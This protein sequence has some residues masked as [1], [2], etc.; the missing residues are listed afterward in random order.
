MA[1][2]SS[3]S[4]S[5]STSSIVS[6]QYAFEMARAWRT[7]NVA[8]DPMKGETFDRPELVRAPSQA[9][10]A[11]AAPLAPP[12]A[13]TAAIEALLAGMEQRIRGEFA[14]QT[15]ELV[16]LRRD[17]PV[18]GGKV[19]SL[20]TE[21]R[22][23]RGMVVAVNK[24]VSN[25]VSMGFCDKVK[26]LVPCC[27]HLKNVSVRGLTPKELDLVGKSKTIQLEGAK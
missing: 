20:T 21:V 22:E 10:T 26:T 16:G 17:I 11:P 1:T 6:S 13:P 25:L 7:D 9:F 19:D 4:S 15:T 3:S 27:N 14:A 24:Q 2:I 12:P 18:V 8:Q 23:L 5:A